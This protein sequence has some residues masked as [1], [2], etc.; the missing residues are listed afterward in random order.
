MLCFLSAS[1]VYAATFDTYYSTDRPDAPQAPAPKAP[2]SV[3]TPAPSAPQTPS[4]SRQ[5]AQTPARVQPR[6]EPISR[7]PFRTRKTVL[8]A[9]PHGVF[10]LKGDFL[11]HA[12]VGFSSLAREARVDTRNTG[13]SVYYRPTN[14]YM[15]VANGSTLTH[16]DDD[17]KWRYQVGIGYQLPNDGNFWYF[18][19]AYDADE[20]RELD[21]SFAWSLPSLAIA[22][23]IPYI[24]FGAN[25]GFGDSQKYAPSSF[26]VLLGVGGYNYLND[27]KSFRLEYGV[28]YSRTEWLPIRHN[29]GNEEWID[30]LWHIYLGAAYRF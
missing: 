1:L 14:D 23:T 2:F 12:S 4:V 17:T 10:G 11:L 16:N 18:D 21:C 29:Y 6:Q 22:N 26:G 27:A 5:P 28:D 13:E 30:D 8:S 24:K 15:G 25:I 3:N 20:T 19:Y 9:A 7:E